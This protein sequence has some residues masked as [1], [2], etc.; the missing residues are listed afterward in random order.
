MVWLGLGPGIG[1]GFGFGFGLSGRGSTLSSLEGRKSFVKPLI[2]HI[3]D[4]V[5][6]MSSK[7]RLAIVRGTAHRCITIIYGSNE[8]LPSEV[9][10]IVL[11]GTSE[12]ETSCSAIAIVNVRVGSI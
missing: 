3:Q 9:W 6:M 12:V 10:V 1:F 4:C 8:F 2:Q 7:L 11:V 5:C